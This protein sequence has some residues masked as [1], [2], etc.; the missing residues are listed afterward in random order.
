MC[1]AVIAQL[2]TQSQRTPFFSALS[3][4]KFFGYAMTPAV[5]A[6]ISVHA[7][8]GDLAIN[9]FTL[10]IIILIFLNLALLPLVIFG[11]ESDLGE[12]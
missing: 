2:T 5:T 3:T 12:Q 7:S 9:D 1:R 11:M 8:V 4:A 10:P 6:A